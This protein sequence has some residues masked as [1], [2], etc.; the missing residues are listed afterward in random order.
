MPQV[1]GNLHWPCSGQELALDA[2]FKTLLLGLNLSP[3]LGQQ[4]HSSA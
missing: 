3:V 4:E 1:V 2:E